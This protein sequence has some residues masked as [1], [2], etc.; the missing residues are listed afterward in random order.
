MVENVDREVYVTKQRHAGGETLIVH[1][2]LFAPV[3]VRLSI[4]NAR[5]VTGVPAAP[6]NWVLPPRQQTAFCV[7]D[8][9]SKEHATACHCEGN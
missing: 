1:N 7:G 2:D 4:S 8:N 9:N 3:E 6:I 5:N